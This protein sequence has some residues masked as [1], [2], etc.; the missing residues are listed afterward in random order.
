M[1]AILLLLVLGW[2]L[3]VLAGFANVS[4]QDTQHLAEVGFQ[5]LFYMTPIIY[6][7]EILEKN[8]IGWLLKY[9]PLVAILRLFREPILLGRA[10]SADTYLTCIGV[11]A[12]VFVAAVFTLARWQR[13]LIFYL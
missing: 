5:L 6:M 12:V 8:H 9:N 2:S 3:A 10:P 7:E 11:V 4:F 13:R 1:P